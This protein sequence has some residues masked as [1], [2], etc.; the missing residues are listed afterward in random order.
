MRWLYK[1]ASRFIWWCNHRW[2]VKHTIN[3]WNPGA[4]EEDG[5]RPIGQKFIMECER[6]GWIK[7]VKDCGC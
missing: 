1:I 6:C 5:D 3:I 2:E 7:I 4:E